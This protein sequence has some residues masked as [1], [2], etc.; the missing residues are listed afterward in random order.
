LTRD[1]PKYVAWLAGIA[2]AI[3]V[4]GTA[5]KPSKRGPETPAPSQAELIRLERLSQRQA[6]I[7]I[8]GYFAGAASRLVLHFVRV[9]ALESSGVVWGPEGRVVAAHSAHPAEFPSTVRAAAGDP[10]PAELLSAPPHLPVAVLRADPAA[11]VAVDHSETHRI[12][13]G[14]WILAVWRPPDRSHSFSPGHFLG[15]SPSTCEGMTAEEI[16]V[17]IPLSDKMLGGGLFDLDG[18]LLG[19][20]VRCGSRPAAISVSSVETAVA[21]SLSLEGRVLTRYGMRAGRLSEAERAYFGADQGLLVR[22]IWQGYPA[23][24][25]GLFPG[26]LVL[27]IGEKEV[28]RRED[29]DPL[30]SP[31]A[32][33]AFEFAVRRGKRNLKMMLSGRTPA[34]QEQKPPA[35]LMVSGAEPGFRV[36]RVL[37]GSPAARAGVRV[38]DHLLAIDGA[39]PRDAAAAAKALAQA[40]EKKVFLALRRGPRV[41]GVL[42]G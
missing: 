9:E 27:R 30:V 4:L 21:E 10:M 26:D 41:W 25:A 12:D 14:Q 19:L 34:A 11:G 2:A 35:G 24:Q 1:S 38:G 39:P 40:G 6:L 28:T 23:G 15:S 31:V 18:N 13:P 42:L 5:L 8:S 7:D 32:P 20:I 33:E 37:P 3:L 17:S 22:E 16:A 36:D 29:L